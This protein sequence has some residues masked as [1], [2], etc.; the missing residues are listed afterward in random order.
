MEIMRELD[1]HDWYAGQALEG[2]FANVHYPAQGS[3]EPMDQFMA[4]V[5]DSA[6]RFARAMVKEGERLKKEAANGWQR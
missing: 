1:L 3:G 5:T 4:R 2:L 6:Y